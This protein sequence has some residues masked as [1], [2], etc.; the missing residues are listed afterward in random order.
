MAAFLVVVGIL[1][2]FEQSS[3]K[4]HKPYNVKENQEK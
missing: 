2:Q 1:A 3:Y 4:V